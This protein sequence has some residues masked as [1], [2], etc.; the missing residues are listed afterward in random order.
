MAWLLSLRKPAKVLKPVANRPVSRISLENWRRRTDRCAGCAKR[1]CSS[2]PN[3][4]ADQRQLP[5]TPRAC[6]RNT[7]WR[8]LTSERSDSGGSA[9]LTSLQKLACLDI[10]RDKLIP[11]VLLSVIHEVLAIDAANVRPLHVD[12]T[13]LASNVVVAASA[14][15]TIEETR[16]GR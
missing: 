3:Y 8:P 10:H 13:T 7:V 16:L 5:V 15:P 1:A 9:D 2:N 14:I 6:S 12:T 4:F 11:T